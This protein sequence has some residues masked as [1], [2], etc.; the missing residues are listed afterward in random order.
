MSIKHLEYLKVKDSK[1]LVVEVRPV[2]CLLDTPLGPTYTDKW[3][4][5]LHWKELHHHLAEVIEEYEEQRAALKVECH[6]PKCKTGRTL[7]IGY[8]FRALPQCWCSLYFLTP[9]NNQTSADDGCDDGDLQDKGGRH[10]DLM[11]CGEM[12]VVSVT[13]RDLCGSSSQSGFS[14]SS[15][16]SHQQ[17]RVSSELMKALGCKV[18]VPTISDYFITPE[19]NDSCVSVSDTSSKRVSSSGPREG[20]SSSGVKYVKR[21]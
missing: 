20:Q 6:K 14:Q 13:L 21:Y 18:A 4:E 3:M 5:H 15:S 17:A 11:A 9:R 12:L 8:M 7:Q 1:L 16:S 19:D 10:E 2:R